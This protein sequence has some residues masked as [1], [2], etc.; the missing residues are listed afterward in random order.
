MASPIMRGTLFRPASRLVC[1]RQVL[2]TTVERTAFTHAVQ[3]TR[4]S[5]TTTTTNY[6]RS[7]FPL[8]CQLIL[9][10]L[11]SYSLQRGN[12]LQRHYA[13][14]CTPQPPLSLCTPL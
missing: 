13:S 6:P 14:K 9:R 3:L 5:L 11:T 4:R 12:P 7:S 1:R 10:V 2:P 8:L